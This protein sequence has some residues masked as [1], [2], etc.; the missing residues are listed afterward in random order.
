[1]EPSTESHERVTLVVDAALRAFVT[2]PHHLEWW[3]VVI[4]PAKAGAVIL[5]GVTDFPGG[6]GLFPE[7]N[8]VFWWRKPAA[9]S[10]LAW[11]GAMVLQVET[12]DK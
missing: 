12:G 11:C 1:M 3:Q 9:V 8:H 5:V 2:R 10:C 4:K 6:S 7:E